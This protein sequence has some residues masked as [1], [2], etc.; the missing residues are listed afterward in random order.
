MMTK[1]VV[2][3]FLFVQ[4]YVSPGIHHHY[5]HLASYLSMKLVIG[6]TVYTGILGVFYAFPFNML[7][8]RMRGVQQTQG[9]RFVVSFER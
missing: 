6:E 1:L 3:V 7:L 4:Y 2:V 9:C 8:D 5:Y